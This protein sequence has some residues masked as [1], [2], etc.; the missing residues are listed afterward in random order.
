MYCISTV[1]VGGGV[2]VDFLNLYLFVILYVIYYTFITNYLHY[3]HTRRCPDNFVIL[4][5]RSNK[6][7]NIKDILRMKRKTQNCKL[8]PQFVTIIVML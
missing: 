1:C 3:I 8:C 2:S 4:N 6:L 5:H 7:I